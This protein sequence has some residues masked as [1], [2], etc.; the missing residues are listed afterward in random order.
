MIMVDSS[1]GERTKL[2]EDLFHPSKI[3]INHQKF[4][5]FKKLVDWCLEII[6]PAVEDEIEYKVIKEK[7]EVSPSFSTVFENGLFIPHLKI[8]N[9]K[10]FYS[11]L[12]ILPDFHP[13]EPKTKRA[14]RVIFLLLS[15]LNQSF[16]EKHLNILAL[17]SSLLRDIETIKKISEFK[18]S[19]EVYSYLKN[20][21]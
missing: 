13:I 15:P 12:I 18:T 10:K 8:E 11:L 7:F 19:D 5:S 14:V 17:V 3:I 9:I 20:L 4:D 1:S 2:F 21:I 16:F 6:Y